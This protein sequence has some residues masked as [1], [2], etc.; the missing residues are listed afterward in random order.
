MCDNIIEIWFNHSCTLGEVEFDLVPY[1]FA[2]EGEIDQVAPTLEEEGGEDMMSMFEP[3]K[4]IL[5]NRYL[6]TTAFVPRW[7]VDAFRLLQYCDD[8]TAAAY[9]ENFTM[10]RIEV[11][12]DWDMQ[13][14][15]YALITIEFDKNDTIIQGKCCNEL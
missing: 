12:A 7:M 2:F 13:Q 15:D 4:R 10:Q 5:K 3:L 1:Y 11:T 9:G 8:V 6:L 14:A